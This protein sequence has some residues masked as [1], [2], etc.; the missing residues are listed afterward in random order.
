MT[1][2]PLNAEFVDRY[3]GGPRPDP[4]TMC[5]GQCEGMGVFPL[6][7]LELNTRACET[8]TGRLLVI[9]QKQ[10]DGS[11]MPEDGWVIVQCPDCN[12]TKLKAT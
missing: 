9:G 2:K 5:K 6:R 7:A 11:P 8:P 1:D 4:K 12:G 10:E 3:T